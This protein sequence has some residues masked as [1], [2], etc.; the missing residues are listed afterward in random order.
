MGERGVSGDII[1][2]ALNHTL[3]KLTRTYQKSDRW[4]ELQD[5]WNRLGEH[6]Q[7]VLAGKKSNVIALPTS[8]AA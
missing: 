1:E 6:L 4:P 2:R 8:K 3:D 7:W 5:A